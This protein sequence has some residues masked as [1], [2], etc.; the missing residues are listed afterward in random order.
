[1]FCWKTG[2]YQR[3]RRTANRESGEKSGRTFV[4]G[5]VRRYDNNMQM[6]RR[7]IDAGEFGELYYA[8]ASILRRLGNP[9]GWFADKARS[10][11][12]L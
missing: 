3:G 9:G 10:G 12:D 8:K 4:V 2:G 11:A 5:F 6:L 1:M 7:F